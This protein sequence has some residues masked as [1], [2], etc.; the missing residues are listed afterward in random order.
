[1][2]K[3]K[4][5]GVKKN[6]TWI[7]IFLRHTGVHMSLLCYTFLFFIASK[8]H[9]NI[10]LVENDNFFS[11]TS[12]TPF[13]SCIIFS[14]C[15]VLVQ[16]A[17]YNDF[18]LLKNCTSDNFSKLF[19]YSHFPKKETVI[20]KNPILEVASCGGECYMFDNTTQ[21]VTCKE[22]KIQPGNYSLSYQNCYID[23]LS[24]SNCVDYV[25]TYT[26]IGLE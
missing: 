11:L 25:C 6:K 14:N 5:T 7:N 9:A 1:M 26:S 10:L 24:N 12:E 21:E 2:N 16:D 18:S 22:R 15:G 13:K 4:K 3:K 23:V 17:S 8:C 19:Y 20:W